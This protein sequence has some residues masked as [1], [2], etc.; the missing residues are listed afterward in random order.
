[1]RIQI[2]ICLFS[3]ILLTGLYGQ[4]F[5]GAIVGQVSDPSGA[6]IP[7]ATIK[8]TNTAT[9]VTVSTSTNEVG[10][11]S[12]LYLTPGTYAVTAEAGGFK[13]LER[14]GIEVRVADRITLDLALEVGG[15][16]ET[17]SVTAETPLLEAATASLGQVVDR[18]RIAD[19]PLADGNPFSLAQLAPGVSF[20]D[21]AIAEQRPFDNNGTSAVQADGAPGGNEFTLD[22]APNMTRKRNNGLPVVAFV[23]P[24]DAVQE[25]KIQTATF[26]AQQ[27][28]TAGANVSVLL[29]SGT[30]QL[31]GT[32]YEFLRNDKLTAKDFFLNRSGGQKSPRRYNRYGFTAGGPV[33]IPK[34]YDGRNRTF[35]FFAYEGIKDIRP[36]VGYYTLPTAAEKNGDLSALT[37]AGVTIYDPATAR[38]LANG[39]VQRDAFPRNSIPASRLSPMSQ[40]VLTFYPEPNLPGD[41]QGRNNLFVPQSSRN[42][43][44]SESARLDHNLTARH[45]F[46]VRYT[47]N[48]RA[49]PGSAWTGIRNGISPVGDKTL[50]TNDGATYDHVY[51]LSPATVINVRGSM[52]R[53]LEPN[54]RLSEG[55]FNP[56]DL[57]FSP[58]TVSYFQGFLYFP[59]IS[60]GGFSGLGSN[61]SNNPTFTV[62]ALQP[63]LTRIKG[64]HAIR[65]GYDGRA[66]R[67]NNITPGHPAGRY[68]FGNTYTRGPL[69]TSSAAPIGQELAAFL[70]GQPTGGSLD[71]N[72]STANQTAGHGFFFQD[73]WKLGRKLTVNL[74]IRYDYEG[75]TTERYNRNVRGFDLT[76][77]SPIEAAA[78]KAYAASPIPQVPAASFRV[79]G[80]LLYAS[81]RQRG[82][83]DAD[84]NNIQPRAGMAY[85]LSPKTVLRA[86]WGIYTAPFDIDAVNQAGFSLATPIVPSLDNGLTFRA[87]FY[88]PFPDGI[89]Q[90]AGSSQGLATNMGLGF[91]VVPVARR[92]PQSHR[93]Q[94]GV[95][96]ELAGGWVV[97]AAYVGTFGYD[98]TL[99]TTGATG[100]GESFGILNPIPAQY[101]STSPTRD[102]AVINLM[103]A[104]VA[105]PFR[106]L[107]P[108]TSLNG[109]TVQRQQLLRPHPQFLDINSQRYEG[110]SRYHSAQFR[111]EKRFSRGYTLMAGYTL[112]RFR[113]RNSYLNPT[114]TRF[115]ERV[116]PND[117]PYRVVVSG[118][119]ELPFGRGRK[120]GSSWNRGL[121]A[122][123][124]GWQVQGIWIAQSGPPMGLGNVYYAGDPAKLKTEIRGA[125]IDRT[126]DTSGFYFTDAAVQRN[127][128]V[129]PALQRSDARINLQYNLRTM[130][131]RLANFRGAGLNNRDISVS[132]NFTVTESVKVQ[133]R[134]EMI[135]AFNHP[136]FSNPNLS[137]S[138]SN[139]AKITSQANLPRDIQ[140]GVKIT[141]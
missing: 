31:H 35:F 62:W 120:V 5:R 77:A 111:A 132:K 82:F 134:G 34:I 141:Y 79:K 7:G 60:I 136:Q 76:S 75:A 71:R 119:Y 81:N 29:K 61:F 6:R 92:N 10:N 133:L 39:R 86:G 18:R 98:L 91:S 24:A 80:G 117:R 32:L 93:V 12:L 48:N 4:E 30:N 94:A 58:Q 123:A 33:Y 127:G 137:P 99:G 46:F 107:L 90:P 3:G 43:F 72:A 109:A 16:Q 140:V 20:Y 51:T 64:S 100:S 118:I 128:V 15:A 78:V 42:N 22:G 25:F 45:R 9:N 113:D 59:Q 52:T 84:K 126:F 97:E 112:S 23:P 138:S 115:E 104:Q 85:Q 56:A 19:L 124:G 17:V 38:L 8:A 110:S 135:N 114:D 1:M 2:L 74:G 96:R 28:H 105:N 27:G 44:H 50:R 130:P 122:I 13:T 49:N 108:G 116:H 14:K 125:T 26:D 36:S 65:I 37:A 121:D 103:T 139:F 106:D 47:H 87:T 73:D 66:Y 101:L 63:T 89:L 83:W 69:D 67:S 102:T 11:Y 68:D 41:S 40:K 54:P 88:N 21:T 70:L 95:Q 57:G 131:T 129:D 53:F 55:H